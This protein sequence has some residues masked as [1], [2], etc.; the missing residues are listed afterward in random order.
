MSFFLENILGV[1]LRELRILY[2]R[3]MRTALRDRSIVVPSVLIPLLVYPILLWGTVSAMTFVRGQEE[4]F[5]SRVAVQDEA[6]LAGDFFEAL[7]EAERVEVVDVPEEPEVAL[8]EGD[9]DALVKVW[10]AADAAANLSG[11]FR[12]AVFHD[13]ARDRSLRAMERVD[14]ALREVRRDWVDRAAEELGFEDSGWEL[15][16]VETLNLATRAQMGAFILGLLVPM[17]TIIMLSIGCLNPAI[18]TIAGERER[19]TWE[20]LLTTGASWTNI[21]VAKYLYVATLGLIAGLLNLFALT[22]SMRTIFGSV[23]GD[24]DANLEFGI[25]LH[26]L[27]V[28]LLAAVSLALLIAAGM[29]LFAVFAHT[30]KEGQS[31][32]M[33]FYLLTLMPALLVNAPDLQLNA[34]WALVPVANV[35]LLFRSALA[36]SVDLGLL[37]LVLLV[38][39]VLITVLLVAARWVLTFDQV[40]LEGQRGGLGVFLRKRLAN[41]RQ[42][43]EGR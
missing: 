20:T 43:E 26:T 1:D 3:E 39:V 5:V 17:L 13:S 14:L 21:V 25:P 33:P 32:V 15:F 9:L 28:V 11:N 35:A 19:S 34:R 40:F 4:R 23:F 12:A 29:M 36:G 10:P 31:M 2:L 18:D 22:L 42:G 16:Q 27:P 24:S 7:E 37:A 41:R 6:G 38:E 8:V 30:F